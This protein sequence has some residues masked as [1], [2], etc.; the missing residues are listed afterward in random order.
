MGE[1]VVEFDI[2]ADMQEEADTWHTKLV[3]KA[4]E[5]DDALMEKFFDAG[6]LS[7]DEIKQGIRK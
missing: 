6:T 7:E 1:V 4:A 5:Q 2:P 3:E